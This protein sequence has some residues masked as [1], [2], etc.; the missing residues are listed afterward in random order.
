MAKCTVDKVIEIAH[1]EKG[2]EEKKS[3]YL[4][5]FKHKNVGK[6][7]YTKY[8]KWIGANGDY[9]CCSYLCWLFYIAYGV[10]KGKQLLC[11]SFSAACETIRQQ[12]IKKKQYHTS[13]P[14]QGDVVFFK[15][16]R[17]AGANHIGLV[18]DVKNGRIYTSEGN[19][20]DSDSDNG[21]AVV[22][23]SYPLN[24]TRIL[25]YGRPKYDKETTVKTKLNCRLYKA[26]N[27]QQ[28]QYAVIG[29][30]ET[31]VFIE[32]LKNGWSKCKYDGKIGYIKNT[33]LDKKGL[34]DYVK[35]IVLV[36]CPVRSKNKKGSPIL[37]R[38]KKGDSVKIIGKGK[39]WVNVLYNDKKGYIFYTK[40]KQVV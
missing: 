27:A 32:D 35:G 9:W 12:F 10:T 11:G 30:E 19:A 3:N 20:D 39:F 14:K 6:N 18:I 2:Y 37:T 24:Y 34:S 17:H 5:E 28:G 8:G 25:G 4:L 22:E 1:Q 21:G 7:N 38:A 33:A 40:V 13:K 29:K 36:D 15:G 26:D 31:V 23:K 16:T